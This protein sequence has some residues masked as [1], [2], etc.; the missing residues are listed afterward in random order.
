MH[1]VAFQIGGFTIYWYGILA[2]AGF[3]IGFWIAGRRAPRDGLRSEAIVD[4]APWLLGGAVV[5]ARA[6]YVAYFWDAEF[7]GKPFWEVFMIRRSGL[8]FYGGL[9]GA[10]L[11]TLLYARLKKLPLWKIADIMAPSIALGHALG[12]IGC[13]MTGCCYGHPTRLPWAIRFPAADHWTRGEPV[14]PTQIYEFALNMVLFAVLSWFYGRKRF[15]GQVFAVYLVAYA[16]VRAFVE[17]F[18]GD[19][20]KYYFNEWVTPGQIGSGV[21]FI[22]GLFLLWRLKPPVPAKEVP[23]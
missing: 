8:V 16:V 23:Q 12:R 21:I 4:L 14:H 22:I 6:W 18:R 20:T 9:I 5:G 15:D 1:P 13:L 2:A 10:S 11:A 3:L 7:A 17:S 19:Y